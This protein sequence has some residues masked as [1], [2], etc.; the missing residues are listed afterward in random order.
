MP[1]HVLDSPHFDDPHLVALLDEPLVNWAT[2][3]WKDGIR[4]LLRKR[5]GSKRPVGPW[6]HLQ[7][8]TPTLDEIR[9]EF[10]PA[11][12]TDGIVAVLDD[13]GLV[14]VDLDGSV[15][16]AHRL[17]TDNGVVLPDSSPR[18]IT[19]S[20]Q[21]HFWFRTDRPVGRHIRL[22]DAENDTKAAIDVLGLGIVILPPSIHPVTGKAYHW[23]PPPYVP[24]LRPPFVLPAEFP[25]LPRRLHELIKESQ[26]PTHPAL[27]PV[28]GLIPEG[29]RE[30]T[31]AKILGAARRLGAQQ[32]ELRAL[33][34][35]TNARCRPSLT[36]RDLDRLAR[37]IARYEPDTLDMAALLASV[38]TATPKPKPAPVLSFVTPVELMA[39]RQTHLDYVAQPYL[40]AGALTDFTGAAKIGKTRFR[41]HLI[42]CLI[43][44]ESCLGYPA[45][46][47][48]K[49][50]LLTEEPVPSLMEGLAAAGLTNTSDLVVLTRYAARAT[51]WPDMVAA[52]DAQ[53]SAIGARVL[54]VDTAPGMA[55]LEGDTENSSGHALAAL[56]PLQETQTPGLAK[57]IIRHTRKSGG[58][59]VEAGRGSSAF[60][61]EADVLIRISKARG[62]RP[63]VRR[64]EA[65]GRFEAIPQML[66]VERVT[67][68][69][70]TPAPPTDPPLPESK[71]CPELIETYQIVSDPAA[72]ADPAAAT[73]ADLVARALPR[74]AFEAK[75][76]A[77]L[78]T[79]L[80]IPERSV[81]H[82]LDALASQVGRRG[83]GTRG[84]PLKFF[85]SGKPRS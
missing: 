55:R 37:S 46:V 15:E 5:K 24:R 66:T 67:V 74:S 72:A 18:V 81:R 34:E 20:G 61:G 63:S 54:M 28:D 17:L 82:G 85:Y 2:R 3:Y 7:D 73:V 4:K 84:D 38:E 45:S 31:L 62:D 52:A 65:I 11:D 47:P 75:T 6:A 64:L 70:S 9:A 26:Q 49:V 8:A 69:C 71:S 41:N 77:E 83:A 48:T 14:V 43:R 29:S 1:D 35:A 68:D 57:F 13:T 42:R 44:G 80:E 79:A 10:S 32:T 60:A 39:D 53:A 21:E 36:G 59:L 19:G 33:A 30:R 51:N 27:A 56:R 22:L 50:V 12:D 78:A 25:P 40:I 16:H 76:A 23:Q 58:D